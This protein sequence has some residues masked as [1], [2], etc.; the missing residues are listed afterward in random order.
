MNTMN[1]INDLRKA[2]KPF[3]VKVK[4]QTLSWGKH[5]TYLVDGTKDS[6]DSTLMAL[7]VGKLSGTLNDE[8]QATLDNLLAFAKWRTENKDILQALRADTGIVG[9]V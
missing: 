2:V 7:G 3:N 5:A 8:Q 6:V 4:T 1:T 9:L